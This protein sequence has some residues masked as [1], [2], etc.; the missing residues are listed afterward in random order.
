MHNLK[1]SS[2]ESRKP[3][4][5]PLKRQPF[6]FIPTNQA[7]GRPRFSSFSASHGQPQPHPSPQSQSHSIQFSPSRLSTP[8]TGRFSPSP[9]ILHPLPPIRPPHAPQWISTSPTQN[10]TPFLLPS[11]PPTPIPIPRFQSNHKPNTH[12]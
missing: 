8:T 4:S 7:S 2:Y 5:R 1:T 9:S 10:G 6:R 3:V 12:P 11:P